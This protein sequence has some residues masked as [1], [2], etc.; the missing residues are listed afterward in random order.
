MR[1]LWFAVLALAGAGF[2]AQPAREVY[3]VPFS[4]LDFYWGG[5]REELVKEGRVEIK[6]STCWRRTGVPVSNKP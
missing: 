3:I 2:G 5:T 4:H 1:S 6:R